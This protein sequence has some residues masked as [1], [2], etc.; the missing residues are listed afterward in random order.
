[1]GGGVIAWAEGGIHRNPASD[2]H[3]RQCRTGTISEIFTNPILTRIG[4]RG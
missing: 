3:Q 4:A 2:H 1:M